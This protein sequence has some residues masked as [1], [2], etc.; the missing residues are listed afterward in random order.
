MGIGKSINI[1]AGVGIGIHVSIG[2]R[3]YTC[4]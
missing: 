4:I 1:H 3:L 2:Y